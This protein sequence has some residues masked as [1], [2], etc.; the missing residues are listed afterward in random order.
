MK[1]GI[2]RLAM[3]DVHVC[4]LGKHQF[5][6][7]EFLVVYYVDKERF[8]VESST[9]SFAPLDNRSIT[10]SMGLQFSSL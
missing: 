7:F 4:A 5:G 9:S 8:P 3:L 6:E 10:V 2:A 1:R